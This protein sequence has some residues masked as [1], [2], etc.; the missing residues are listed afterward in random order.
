MQCL[1]SD[2]VIR[3]CGFESRLLHVTL[4]KCPSLSVS[5]FLHLKNGDDGGDDDDDCDGD[6]DIYILGLF[7]GH[8]T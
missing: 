2:S 6:D 4:G 1:P 3:P 5:Y 7:K 8:M